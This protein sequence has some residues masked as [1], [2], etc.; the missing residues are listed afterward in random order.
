MIPDEGP[1]SCAGC[2]TVVEP[3]P[4][5]WSTQVSARGRTWLCERCTRDNARSIEG[6]LDEAWW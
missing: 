4:L 6:R 3:R 1:V 2:G 5:T